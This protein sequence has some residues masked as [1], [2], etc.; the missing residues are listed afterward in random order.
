VGT[1]DTAAGVQHAFLWQDG[2][3]ADLGTLGGRSSGAQGI[4]ECGQVVGTDSARFGEQA[5]L[6][7]NG[8]MISLGTAGADGS[9]AHAINDQGQIVG[10]ALLHASGDPAALLWEIGT[11]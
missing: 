10:W 7:Q 1:S 6:W 3:M 4:N 8:L 2:T 11:E 5:F 9:S